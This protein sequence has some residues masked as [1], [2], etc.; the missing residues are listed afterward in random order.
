MR[1]CRVRPSEDVY[2][3]SGLHLRRAVKLHGKEKFHKSVLIEGIHGRSALAKLE[4]LIVTQELVD[5]PHCYNMKLGGGLTGTIGNTFSAK[6]QQSPQQKERHRKAMDAFYASDEAR[7][8]ARIKANAQWASPSFVESL[9]GKLAER[10][11]NR[12]PNK[13]ERSKLDAAERREK[14]SALKASD[15]RVAKTRSP[16]S[17]ETKKKLSD[18]LRGRAKTAVH[19][20]RVAE[21]LR[22]KSLPQDVRDKISSTLTG[23]T[24]AKHSAETIARMSENWTPERREAQSKRLSGIPRTNEVREK[25][26]EKAKAQH[27]RMRAG[28]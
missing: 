5:D 24:G 17:A 10:K 26:R 1:S 12:G 8:R 20:A 16:M 6:R 25:C 7:Q 2:F 13:K 21:S 11:L 3:G 18:A 4:S 9:K 27:A 28:A 14:R 22:G 19:V 15:V 23:R